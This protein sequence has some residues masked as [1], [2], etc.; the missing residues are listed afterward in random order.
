MCKTI[1]DQ[2]LPGHNVQ[3]HYRPIPAWP[4]CAR[5]LHLSQ[6]NECKEQKRCCRGCKENKDQLLIPKGILQEDKYRKIKCMQG[7]GKLSESC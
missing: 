5:P 4:Q 3:D 7:M 6:A 2:Y 1:T